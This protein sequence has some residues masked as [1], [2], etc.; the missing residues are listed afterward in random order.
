MRMRAYTVRSKP[1][2]SLMFTVSP[3]WTASTAPRY[4]PKASGG[5]AMSRIVRLGADLVKRTRERGPSVSPNVL[6]ARK[7]ADARSVQQTS[8][9]VSAAGGTHVFSILWQLYRSIPTQRTRYLALVALARP[10]FSG[11][12][13]AARQA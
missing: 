10:L 1:T 13:L 9:I 6:G 11:A 8:A 5:T 2:S 7:I 12:F 4:G 3:S